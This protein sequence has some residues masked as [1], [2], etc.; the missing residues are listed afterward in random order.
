MRTIINNIWDFESMEF[1]QSAL[2]VQ[3][4]LCLVCG[5]VALIIGCIYR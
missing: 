5:I 3:Y 2:N 1:T 4:F